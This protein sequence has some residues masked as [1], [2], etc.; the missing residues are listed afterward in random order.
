MTLDRLLLEVWC[1]TCQHTHIPNIPTVTYVCTGR[2][3]VTAGCGFGVW[4]SSIA[5]EHATDYPDHV[6]YPRVHTVV[7]WDVEWL[8]KNPQPTAAGCTT[9]PNPA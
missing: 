2:D 1:L 6:V 9:Q 7:E 5:A 4:D 8:T 3:P